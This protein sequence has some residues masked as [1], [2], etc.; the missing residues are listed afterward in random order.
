MKFIQRGALRIDSTPG[1]GPLNNVAFKNPDGSIV[2]IVANDTAASQ[3]LSIS[4][5]GTQFDHSL[6]PYSVA[7]YRFRI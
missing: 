2:V 4:C 1:K 5:A 6:T 3:T 7:T